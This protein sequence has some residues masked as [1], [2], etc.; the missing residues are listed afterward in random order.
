V[1]SSL[2]DL[3]DCIPGYK[4][5]HLSYYYYY[6]YYLDK[7]VHLQC[8]VSVKWGGLFDHYPH[9]YCRSAA[10]SHSHA[11]DPRSRSAPSNWVVLYPLLYF[12]RTV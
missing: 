5:I 12:I 3:L 6:Y 8:W 11:P 7:L 4:Y 1:I 10:G 2:T 9:M